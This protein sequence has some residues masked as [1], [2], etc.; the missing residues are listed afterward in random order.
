MNNKYIIDKAI[1]IG[2]GQH[3][4]LR[5]LPSLQKLDFIKKIIIFDLLQPSSEYH[6]Y[7]KTNIDFVEDMGEALES[8]DKSTL[9]IIST[10][11]NARLKIFKQ[12]VE[13]GVKVLYL[14]KPISQSLTE[15]EEILNISR[16]KKLKVAI[17]TFSNYWSISKQINRYIKDYDLGKLL[18]IYSAGGNVGLAVNGIHIIDLSIELFKSKPI[19]VYGRIT[20]R[21]E[22]PRGKIFFNHGGFAHILFPR[23]RELILSYNNDSMI[24]YS[25]EL[26]F[27]FGHINV[28]IGNKLINIYGID[29]SL[30]NLPK[31]R[32]QSTKLL[33]QEPFK[34]DIIYYLTSLFTVLAT[35]DDIGQFR[36]I[37]KGFTVF[38]ALL[39]V[40]MSDLAGRS[41]KLPIM[42]NNKYYSKQFPIT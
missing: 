5:I 33:L 4:S 37:E 31:Y 12:F 8:A 11:A 36:D 9:V 20:S 30:Q 3:G 7:K 2:F 15:A 21:G 28:D 29:K 13:R 38:N 14:E 1:I 6:N 24:I 10:T 18:K 27:E 17:G 34:H 22:N 35:K 26:T 39:G 25:V 23:N 42:A 40:F 16:K 32:Y 41:V 19:E